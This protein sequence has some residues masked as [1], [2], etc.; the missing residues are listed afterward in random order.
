MKQYI[1]IYIHIYIYTRFF[2][3]CCAFL[4]ESFRL[5][6]QAMQRLRSVLRRKC[7]GLVVPHTS[8]RSELGWSSGFLVVLL[9]SW[10]QTVP[11][12][13]SFVF[14]CR[15]TLTPRKCGILKLYWENIVIY[16]KNELKILNLRKPA[17]KYYNFCNVY[18]CQRT[19][20]CIRVTVPESCHLSSI[21]GR[22]K[23]HFLFYNLHRRPT[24]RS[25]SIK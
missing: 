23:N 16:A 17:Y 20:K 3:L 8:T 19:E 15:H 6:Y 5:A 4:S 13:V 12:S 11:K 24:L 22:Q 1:Y 21:P 10:L 18:E 25:T 7:S 14:S 2:L 9:R